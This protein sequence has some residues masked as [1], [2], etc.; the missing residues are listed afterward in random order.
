[1]TTVRIGVAER[2]HHLVEAG[3]IWAEATAARDGDTEVAP[4]GPAT[5]LV[6]RVVESSPRSLLVV[7]ADADERV[8]GFAAA[9]PMASD[10]STAHLR[11]VAVR[12][13]HWGGGVGRQLVAALPGVLAAGGFAHGELEV[14][15]DNPR[16]VKLYES[17]GWHPVGDAEPH[18]RSGRV[19][20]RYRLDF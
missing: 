4:S 18:P 2:G 15:V 5:A 20:Q 1:M 17:L 7:A 8:V 14:Y 3:A 10:A 6:Q 19:E 13:G 12:P 11:F 16:A 9:E